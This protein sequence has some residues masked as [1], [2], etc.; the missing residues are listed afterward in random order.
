MLW[1]IV[2]QCQRAPK[3]LRRLA[4]ADAV[5][6]DGCGALQCGERHFQAGER[7]AIASRREQR[8][9]P[10]REAYRLCGTEMQQRRLCGFGVVAHR[11]HEFAAELEMRR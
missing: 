6:L 8:Q 1:H 9:G 3:G 2:E 11:C 10:V 4:G 5:K 7:F